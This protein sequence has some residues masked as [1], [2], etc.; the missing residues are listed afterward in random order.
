MP[1]NILPKTN[2]LDKH[3]NVWENLDKFLNE[4]KSA[5]ITNIYITGQNTDALL[6]KYLSDLIDY[7]KKREFNVGIRTNGYLAHD[8]T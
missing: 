7:I 1:L 6:Y 8:Q 5:K 2:C 3:Y 4:C